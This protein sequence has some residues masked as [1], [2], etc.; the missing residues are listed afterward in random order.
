ME[1]QDLRTWGEQLSQELAE[2]RSS[3][4]SKKWRCPPELISRIVSYAKVCRERGEPFFDIA[5]RLGLVESTLTRWFR[6][7]KAKEQPGFRSVSIVR[8]DDNEETI[9]HPSASGLR[10]LTPQGYR[11]E[12]L[13]AQTLAYLLRVL[14]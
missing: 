8:K 13:D 3:G 7:E 14:P 4:R 1:D 5:V 9:A 10:L 6:T 11:V 2:G 12:G